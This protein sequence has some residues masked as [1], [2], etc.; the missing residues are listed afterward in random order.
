MASGVVEEMTDAE[1]ATPTDSDIENS[2][3]IN[4]KF[5]REAGLEEA[6]RKSRAEAE[7]LLG[8]MKKQS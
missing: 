7:T 1:G 5:L 8:A 2:A 6:L 3:R 4:V